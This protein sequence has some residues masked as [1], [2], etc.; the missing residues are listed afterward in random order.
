MKFSTCGMLVL[1]TLSGLCLDVSLKPHAVVHGAPSEVAAS[2]VWDA[3][4]DAWCNAWINGTRTKG[5][6]AA[7]PY[8]AWLRSR[9][10]KKGCGHLYATICLTRRILWGAPPT[11]H[12]ALGPAGYGLKRYK[13]C[14]K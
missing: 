2:R 5:V 9:R 7:C 14:A 4:A 12:P 1:T 11:I 6:G 13:L 8:V 10:K 3:K